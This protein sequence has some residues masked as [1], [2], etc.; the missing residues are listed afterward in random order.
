MKPL[1]WADAIAQNT[2]LR[3]SPNLNFELFVRVFK[4]CDRCGSA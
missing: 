3:R 2:Q 4:Y 1:R